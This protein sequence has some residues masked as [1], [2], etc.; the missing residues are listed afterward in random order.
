M[1]LS[2]TLFTL[3][4]GP[5]LSC[6]KTLCVV[7]LKRFHWFKCNFF[8]FGC[9]ITR[10]PKQNDDCL[11]VTVYIVDEVYCIVSLTI[12]SITVREEVGVHWVLSEIDT[13]C[14]IGLQISTDVGAAFQKFNGA[15]VAIAT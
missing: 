15:R 12:F 3:F 8:Y 9:Y 14:Y 2:M 11:P 7:I 1:N 4:F 6:C 13:M 10:L 5:C